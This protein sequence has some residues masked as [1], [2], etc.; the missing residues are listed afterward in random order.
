MNKSENQTNRLMP[1][2]SS[3]NSSMIQWVF[4]ASSY[5]KVVDEVLL[6]TFAAELD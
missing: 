6:Y 3:L 1:S 2:T 4:V 5:Y